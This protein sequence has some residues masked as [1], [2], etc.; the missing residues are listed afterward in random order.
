VHPAF[1][2]DNNIQDVPRV[3]TSLLKTNLSIDFSKAP[4]IAIEEGGG[5]YILLVT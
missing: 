3:F 2:F 5:G 4:H 1:F